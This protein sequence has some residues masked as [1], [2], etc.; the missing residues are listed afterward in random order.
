MMFIV[1]SCVTQKKITVDAKSGATIKATS[2]GNSLYHNTELINMQAG[3]LEVT[4]EVQNGGK[5]DFSK[6]YKKEVFVKEALVKGSDQE[7]IGAYRYSGYSLFDI[8]NEFKLEKKNVELFRPEIDLYIVI[9]ND[10]NESVVFSWSEIFHTSKLHEII[11][12]TEAAPIEPHRKSV[13]YPVSKTWK[14]VAANDLYSHR[15]IENPT[16]LTVLSFNKKDYTIKR[17]LDPVYSAELKIVIDNLSSQAV[18]DF[19]IQKPD[20]TENLFK[21]NSTFYGMGMGYHPSPVFKGILLNDEFSSHINLLDNSLIKNG[22][23]CFVSVDG[24]RAIFSFSELFNRVDQVSPMLAITENGDGGYYRIYL[25][26][27]FYADRS[28]KGLSEIF[29]FK[30]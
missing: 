3:A 13:S 29:L 30:E 6:F 23:L 25:P 24:Y 26:S 22:L 19:Y 15:N 2:K 1:N 18:S 12:A 14:I 27:D 9:E 10:K 7:F 8:L 21:Y 16:R 4:G 5:V 20:S 17:D 28:V 11:L